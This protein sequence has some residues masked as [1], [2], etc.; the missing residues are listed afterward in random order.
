[1]FGTR[2]TFY[3][4]HVTQDMLDCVQ[5]GVVPARPIVAQSFEACYDKM[6]TAIFTEKQVIYGFLVK[7]PGPRFKFI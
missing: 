5:A 6:P 3:L 2:P 7:K 4:F 1:M